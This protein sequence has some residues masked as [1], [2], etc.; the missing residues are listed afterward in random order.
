MN[1]PCSPVFVML[2]SI[3]F[4]QALQ[5][6]LKNQHYTSIKQRIKAHL[7]HTEPTGLL[8]FAGSPREPMPEGIPCSAEDYFDLVDRTARQQRA[9]KTGFMDDTL[10]PILQRL[11]LTTEQWCT[12]SSGV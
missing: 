12:A 5:K 10:S 11:G 9:G 6:R 4:G 2:I 7:N 3:L 1:R 8:P